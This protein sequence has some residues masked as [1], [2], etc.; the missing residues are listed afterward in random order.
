MSSGGS[1]TSPAIARGAVSSTTARTIF[2]SEA[3]ILGSLVI[4]ALVDAAW[5]PVAAIA[6]IAFF[7]IHV[8]LLVRTRRPGAGRRSASGTTADWAGVLVAVIAAAISLARLVLDHGQDDSPEPQFEI[9]VPAAGSPVGQCVLVQGLGTP[10]AEYRLWTVVQSDGT[11]LYYPRRPVVYD[12]ISEPTS[13]SVATEVGLTNQPNPG[14]DIVIVLIPD[15]VSTIWTG[16]LKVGSLT[17]YSELPTGSREVDRVSVSRDR[18]ASKPC[19]R[20][21][22]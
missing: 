1:N 8:I 16:A 13:W 17:G 19:T 9:I 21:G 15:D 11:G 20:A 3:V 5:S 14:Y 6:A 7:A 12:R 4:V 22:G 2:A 10:K 18:G